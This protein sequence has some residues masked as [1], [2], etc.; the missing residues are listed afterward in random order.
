MSRTVSCF[1]RDCNPQ[2]ASF[3]LLSRYWRSIKNPETI[4]FVNGNSLKESDRTG[5]LFPLFYKNK[6]LSAWKDGLLRYY[7]NYNLKLYLM[8]HTDHSFLWLQQRTNLK[9]KHFTL[10]THFHISLFKFKSKLLLQ[11]R[12][13]V[14][15]ISTAQSLLVLCMVSGSCAEND[16]PDFKSLG[17]LAAQETNR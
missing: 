15:A 2:Y 1:F 12:C 11:R 3:W 8:Q 4:R 6:T 10:N 7:S 5:R 16:P 14:C 17:G 13:V 9:A